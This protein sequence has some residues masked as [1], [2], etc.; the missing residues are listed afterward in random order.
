VSD[1]AVQPGVDPATLYWRGE[2]CIDSLG[3]RREAL[4]RALEDGL[5]V[6]IDVSEVARI[7]TAGLQLL[8]AFVLDMRRNGRAVKCVAAS[9]PVLQGARLAGICELLG[10]ESAES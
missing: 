8:L 5:P 9:A 3:E 10:L 2:C 1:L 7:D 6:V 4:Q